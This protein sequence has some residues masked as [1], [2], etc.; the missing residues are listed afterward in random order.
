MFHKERG[1]CKKGGLNRKFFGFFRTIFRPPLEVKKIS[2]S[3]LTIFENGLVLVASFF[4]RI[5]IPY[6]PMVLYLGCH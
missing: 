5:P 3:L 2:Y 6:A 4:F 1:W